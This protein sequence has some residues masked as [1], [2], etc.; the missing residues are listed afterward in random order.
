MPTYLNKANR[1]KHAALKTK[2]YPLPY[3]AET[4]VLVKQQPMGR[5][6]QYAEASKA[7]GQRAAKE[8]FSLVAESIVDEVGKPVWEASEVAE[9]VE[10]NCQL[11]SALVKMIGHA[12]GGSD[13]DIEDMLGNLP[14]TE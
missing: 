8:T 3:D 13:Q 12:N 4:I 6:N 11:V 9:L 2:P 10:S 5:M 1:D 14:T 7:G